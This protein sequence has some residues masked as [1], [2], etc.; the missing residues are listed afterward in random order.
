MPLII[1][2]LCATLLQH[3]HLSVV[4]AKPCGLK[5]L[6]AAVPAQEYDAGR[7]DVVTRRIRHLERLPIIFLL[8]IH[9]HSFFGRFH[10]PNVRSLHRPA[11]CPCPAAVVLAAMAG[12]AP[13][14]SS[15]CVLCMSWAHA[16][17]QPAS[18]SSSLALYLQALLNAGVPP[19]APAFIFFTEARVQRDV[20]AHY[21]AL[22][23]G[24]GRPLRRRP[25]A[26]RG[27]AGVEPRLQPSG[28]RLPGAALVSNSCAW[29][30]SAMY[31]ECPPAHPT[32]PSHS[33]VHIEPA[34]LPH[35]SALQLLTFFSFQRS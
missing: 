6:N 32:H 13:A 21:Y 19:F 16:A 31:A 8:I 28:P 7:R 18:T 35:E 25:R 3:C 20:R 11:P 14:A 24:T 27:G 29:C 4:Q 12:H 5:S 2:M 30:V 33:T 23:A 17:S 22:A 9:F 34:P 26:Q 10:A 15:C 1:A